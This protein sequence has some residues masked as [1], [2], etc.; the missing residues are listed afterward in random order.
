MLSV[1]P[2][3]EK[4]VVDFLVNKKERLGRNFATTSIRIHRE[5]DISL[6]SQLIGRV[7]HNLTEEE[8]LI[9]VKKGGKRN[10]YVTNF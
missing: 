3:D 8:I 9:C 6:S 5:I 1:S 10:R 2:D 4:A 7:L